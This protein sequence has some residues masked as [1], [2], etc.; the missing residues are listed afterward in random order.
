MEPRGPK[1]PPRR[2][3]DAPRRPQEA[4]APG[5]PQD[6]P[7]TPKSLIFLRWDP[8]QTLHKSPLGSTL[9][10]KP[11]LA[12]LAKRLKFAYMLVEMGRGEGVGGEGGLLTTSPR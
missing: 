2:P 9:D 5:R 3:Q 10:P 4:Q 11:G 12:G 6:A 8:Q 1:T 7:G